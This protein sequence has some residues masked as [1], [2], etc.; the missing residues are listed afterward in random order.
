MGAAAL[1]RNEVVWLALA[2]AWLAWRLRD[3]PRAVRVRLIAVVAVVS[4]LVFAPWAIRDWV[5]FGNP[6]PGQAL[7]NALSVTGFD[8]FAWNDPPTLARYLAIGPAGL[9][10]MRVVG[11]R[12]QPVQRP[13]ADRDPD[14]DPRAAGAARGRAA[15]A[16][17]RPVLLTGLLTFLATSLAVPG[18]DDLGHLPPRRRPG[19]RPA[20][21]LRARRA[22]R[23]ASPGSAPARLDAARR[24]ARPAARDLRLALFSCV[25]LPSFGGG[26]ASTARTY[27]V[28]RPPDGRHRR[29]ARRQ[30]TRHPRLPDLA[31]RDGARADA[32]PAQ[33]DARGRPRPRLALRREVADRRQDRPRP[34]AG[35]P[36]RLRSRT[37]PASRRCSCRSPTTRRTPRPSTTCGSSASRARASRAPSA[38]ES[39]VGASE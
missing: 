1:T 35:G 18:R 15:T 16:P 9:L 11:H 3:Q 12:P 22:R 14:L 36:R 33:R 10:E 30:R 34:V 37:P 21:D 20:A 31:G 39:A 28:A 2:W 6:L 13:A 32:R 26:A 7:S 24:L 27:D 25:L 4:L 19:P 17:L 29:A 23:R 5:V 38:P 8:I